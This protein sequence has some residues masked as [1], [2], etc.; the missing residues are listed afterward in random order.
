MQKI[1]P[2]D[3][4]YVPSRVC[5]CVCMCECVYVCICVYMSV[6]VIM[7]TVAFPITYAGHDVG[8]LKVNNSPQL[9]ITISHI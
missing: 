3:M 5:V 1:S 6:C 4:D 7:Q 8:V 9:C 2:L